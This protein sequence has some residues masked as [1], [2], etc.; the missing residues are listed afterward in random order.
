MEPLSETDV[1]RLHRRMGGLGM[2]AVLVALIGM[3]DSIFGSGPLINDPLPEQ[4]I[5]VAFM[6]FVVIPITWYAAKWTFTSEVADE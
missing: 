3:Y 5:G 2:Y 6:L 1:E 4:V